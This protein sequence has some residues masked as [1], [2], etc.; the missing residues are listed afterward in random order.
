MVMLIGIVVNNAILLVDY[1]N[2]M[3]REDGMPIEQAVV[4]AGRLRLRPILM[5]TLTTVLGLIPL[6]LGIGAGA[7]MQASLARVVVGGLMAS[8]LI[9]LVFIPV[10]YVTANHTRDWIGNHLVP[11]AFK[12]VFRKEPPAEADTTPDRAHGGSDAQ[13]G[14]SQQRQD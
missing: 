4:K 14:F 1:I 7:E 8:T 5:T 13:H 9:T 10:F 11:D 6:A 2:I 3:R 12:R